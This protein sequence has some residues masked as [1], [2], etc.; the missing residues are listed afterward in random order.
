MGDLILSAIFDRVQRLV[1]PTKSAMVISFGRLDMAL[2]SLTHLLRV[3]RRRETMSWRKK[4][5]LASLTTNLPC[6]TLNLSLSCRSTLCATQ[7]HVRMR[8]LPLLAP[9]RATLVRFRGFSGSKNR[10]C[11]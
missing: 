10:V 9:K 7:V 5:Y 6:S 11:L 3:V 4:G 8:I 2:L 1:P